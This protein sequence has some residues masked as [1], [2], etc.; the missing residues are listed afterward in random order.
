MRTRK[1]EQ[2][3]GVQGMFPQENLKFKSSEMAKNTSKTV[4]K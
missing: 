4:L 1:R 3:K 2:I